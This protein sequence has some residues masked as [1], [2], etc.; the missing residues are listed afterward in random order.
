MKT[1][2]LFGLLAVLALAAGSLVACGGDEETDT[3][4]TEPGVTTEPLTPEAYAEEVRVVL[5][6]LG[7]NLQELGGSLR[8]T[9]DPQVLAEGIGEA[10]Q[11]LRDS[12]E[13]LESVTPP[14]E[15]EQVHEDLIA[16]IEGFADTLEDT[17][18][19]AEDE[20]VEELQAAALELPGAAQEF[21][22]ELQR[23]QEAAIDAG[24]PLGPEDDE[25][26][27]N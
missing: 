16:A 11:E 21:A 10:Q 26:E 8:E 14:E 5:E 3:T 18:Q 27:G 13:Q 12:V 2:R 7:D 15:V 20:N 1:M 9:D 19:A 25:A 22:A 17:R 23:I 4:S 6:P 24:V